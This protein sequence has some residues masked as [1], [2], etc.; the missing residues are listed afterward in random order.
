M[1]D[2]TKQWTQG[3]VLRRNRIVHH[4]ALRVSLDIVLKTPV[5]VRS[6]E[7]DNAGQTEHQDE[8]QWTMPLSS[9]FNALMS[10]ANMTMH[11]ANAQGRT[12]NI[13]KYAQSSCSKKTAVS[14]ICKTKCQDI[15]SAATCEPQNNVHLE[16]PRKSTPEHLHQVS[17]IYHSAGH[18]LPSDAPEGTGHCHSRQATYRRIIEVLTQSTHMMM[19]PAES[20]DSSATVLPGEHRR[21]D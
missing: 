8:D 13:L 15:F 20:T 14:R 19:P 9:W 5:L 7:Y 11:N 4:R 2:S 16:P 18:R 1:T 6:V 12:G 3:I 10:L 17:T 21:Q